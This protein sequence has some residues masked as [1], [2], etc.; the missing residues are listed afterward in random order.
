MLKPVPMETEAAIKDIHEAIISC[1]FIAN[2]HEI[3]VNLHL[4][5]TWVAKGTQLEKDF[6][7][8]KYTPPTIKDIANAVIEGKNTSDR[9][10]IY[11]GIDDEGLAVEGG[12]YN[13][14]LESKDAKHNLYMFNITQDYKYITEILEFE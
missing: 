11:I 4:N 13:E 12:S 1:E 6:N 5:P 2:T 10:S 8:G 9:F 14:M 7:E 3:N